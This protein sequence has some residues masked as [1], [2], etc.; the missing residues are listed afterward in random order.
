LLPR[1]TSLLKLSITEISLGKR[2]EEIDDLQS[3]FSATP[4]LHL[5]LSKEAFVWIEN[6]H[7]VGLWTAFTSLE[8]YDVPPDQLYQILSYCKQLISLTISILPE[9]PEGDGYVMMPN[10]LHLKIQLQ[11]F[12]GD[13][14][15]NDYL[16]PFPS[17]L[18]VPALTSLEV[19]CAKVHFEDI[20]EF[21]EHSAGKLTS[22]VW[23][24]EVVAD[25]SEVAPRPDDRYVRKFLTLLSSASLVNLTAFSVSSDILDS[26]ADR[27]LLPQ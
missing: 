13:N 10:L 18:L 9:D 17:P 24:D 16:A 21:V 22:F 14:S 27:T 8:L 1:L 11:D 3:P 20:I 6:L 5:R 12:E 23:D 2:P 25:L 4:T 15:D 19:S 26:I 7:C